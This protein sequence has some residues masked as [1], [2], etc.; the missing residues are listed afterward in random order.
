MNNYRKQLPATPRCIK[1]TK[2]AYTIF[3]HV[4]FI[5]SLKSKIDHDK[6]LPE[7]ERHETVV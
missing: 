3:S 1:H 7:K 4:G 5:L 6:N 2:P